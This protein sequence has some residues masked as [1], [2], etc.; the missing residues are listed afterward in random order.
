MGG[1]LLCPF[2]KLISLPVFA[3]PPP[4]SRGFF[5]FSRGGDFSTAPL[6][7]LVPP[8]SQPFFLVPPPFFGLCLG[9][10]GP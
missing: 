1:G 8:L 4:L 3:G 10:G 2:V 5:F 7:P 9:P 6:G